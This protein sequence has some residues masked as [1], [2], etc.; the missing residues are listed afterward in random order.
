MPQMLLNLKNVF[1]TCGSQKK[2]RA[3]R[4]EMEEKKSNVETTE[5]KDNTNEKEHLDFLAGIVLFIISVSAIIAS[6]GYWKKQGVLFYASAGFMPIIVCSVLLLLSIFLFL[7]SL[8]DSSIKERWAQVVASVPRTLKSK[9]TQRS[10]VGLAIFALYV[11]VLLPAFEFVIS[12]A[13]TLVIALIYAR[14][15]KT[16]RG[17]L[18]M[19]LIAGVAI[20]LIYLLFKVAFRVPLP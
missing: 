1:R 16:F 20:G 12:S 13:I 3:R 11:F 17:I 15:E 19:I 4:T 8:K 6:I 10:I 5:Q 9:F 2:P 14:S 7:G 18:K